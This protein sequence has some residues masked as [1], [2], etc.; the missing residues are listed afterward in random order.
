MAPLS[1]RCGVRS[2]KLSNVGWVTK[3]LLSGAPLCVGRHVKPLVTAAF[4][5]V[6]ANQHRARVVGYDPF[7]LCVINKE[8]MC[9]QAG[10]GDINWLMMMIDPFV[11]L[12]GPAISAKLSHRMEWPKIIISSSSVFRKAR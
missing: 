6:T 11:E 8:G 12:D 10:S 1:V 9:R 5:V 4:V 2:P 7:S 3:N